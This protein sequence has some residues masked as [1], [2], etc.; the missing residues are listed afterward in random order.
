M[1]VRA[2][3]YQLIARCLYKMGTYNILRRCVLEHERPIILVGSHES[4]AGG[5]YCGQKSIKMLGNIAINVMSVRGWQS[6]QKG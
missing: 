2:A 1:V 6:Q 3:Y 5:H 4:V